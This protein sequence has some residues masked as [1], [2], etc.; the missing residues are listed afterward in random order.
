MSF[1][2]QLKAAVRASAAPDPE[3][4]LWNTEQMINRLPRKERIIVRNK[5][6]FGLILAIILCMLTLTAVAAVL[7]TSQELVETEVLPMALENDHAHAPLVFTNEELQRIAALAEENNI[8]LGENTL[9]DLE[10][11]LDLPERKVIRE[12]AY[13]TF[14]PE[15][16]F[17]PLEEQYWFH[18][19]MVE[20]GIL[21]TNDHLLPGADDLT[22]TEAV[23]RAKEELLHRT[24]SGVAFLDNPDAYRLARSY[25]LAYNED[26]QPTEKL[27]I[28]GFLDKERDFF[29]Q[30]MLNQAGEYIGSRM[31]EQITHNDTFSNEELQHIVALAEEN[32]ITLS[33]RILTALE[34][35]E[36]YWEEEVIMSLAKSQFGP[37]P[38]QWTLE[39]QYWFE[40][41][42]VA[43]GFQDANY[44]LIP[45]EG[46]LTYEEAYAKAIQYLADEGWAPDPAI[47]EDRT[48]YGLWRTYQCVS[49]EAGGNEVPEWNFI[50]DPKDINLPTLSVLM[51]QSGGLENIGR[52][53]GMEEQLAAGT[54]HANAVR[55]FFTE[56][57]GSISGWPPEVFVEYV[58]ALRQSDLTNISSGTQAYLDTQ[59]I[60]PPKGSLTS[61]QA[62]EIAVALIGGS[63]IRVGGAYC[64]EVDGRAIWKVTI[65]SDSS[66]I[67]DMVEMDAM[68]GDILEV[69]ETEKQGG[70][71]QFYV[72]HAVW[73]AIPTPNPEGNG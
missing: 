38:G 19:A 27:W 21:K 33:S 60:V 10:N 22:E 35:G 41:T 43:I 2:E 18:Q 14:G 28:I 61:G 8:T 63:E 37:Y 65:A 47:L 73:T 62:V 59:Y 71:A 20:L 54:L 48:K 72:P 12:L 51:N 15:P 4:F 3:D 46:D 53:A 5:L 40:E 39:E 13:N 57:Y 68:T 1:D 17:W 66:R 31:D 58:A 24:D 50:F 52:M 42:L 32:G 25:Q 36:G 67:S 69:Y 34:K 56:M 26:G 7:L 64:F 45:G 30:V 49:A 16:M 44:C 9:M 55:D 6:S 70:A 23:A 11:G 29:Y